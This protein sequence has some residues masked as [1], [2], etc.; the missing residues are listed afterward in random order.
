VSFDLQL[1]DVKVDSQGV[2]D[3]IIT[4]LTATCTFIPVGITEADILAALAIQG[5]GVRRGAS[6]GGADFTITGS[7]VG[8]PIFTLH[9][10]SVSKGGWAF[11]RNKKRIGE[12]QL[13][14]RR[15]MTT[16]V[17]DPLWT[18]GEVEEEE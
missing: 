3:K 7:E 12:I 11:A 4:S 1:E 10:A 9:S 6:I 15:T 14:T 18:T 17:L 5:A 2:V 13:V 16:G 8:A